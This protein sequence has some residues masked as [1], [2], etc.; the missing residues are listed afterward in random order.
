MASVL[1]ES[2]LN[3]GEE[4][5]QQTVPTLPDK[6]L[7][8]YVTTYE[9]FMQWRK[10]QNTIS[11]DEEVL[12]AYFCDSAKSMKPSTLWCIYSM[13]KATISSNH[14]VNIGQYVRLKSFLKKNTAGFES[15]IPKVLTV[16]EIK[17][18]L[19]KAPDAKY[20]GVKVN[21]LFLFM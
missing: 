3:D 10:S 14:N 6:S 12:L 15:T 19:V 1:P 2:I 7:A 5:Q 4:A 13:L 21:Q 8:R 18:F 20:L 11:F 16:E 9:K 17:K